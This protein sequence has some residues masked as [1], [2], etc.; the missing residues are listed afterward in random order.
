MFNPCILIPVYNHSQ[1]ISQTI[2]RI[3]ACSQLTII[4]VDDGSDLHHQQT[5]QQVAEQL[6]GDKVEL[7]HL[8]KNQGKG[9]AVIWGFVKA[10]E[11]GFS[12]ALQVDADGQHACEDIP[13][14]I[15]IAEQQPTAVVCGI[16]KYDASVPKGRLY[17]RY[18]TH[19]FVW[20]ETLSLT[21]K[22]SMCGFRLYPLATTLPLVKRCKLGKR[23]D[24][25]TEI[26]VRLYWQG[27]IIENFP[28]R[29]T[30][31]E[32]GASHFMMFKDNVLISWM[33]TRLTCGMLLRSPVLVMRNLKRWCR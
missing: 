13:A 4:L 25:D 10:A 20:L 33:H 7:Y 19:V 21:I 32:D 16:P 8:D 5:L 12:H 3:R 11:L 22:D 27:A 6:R 14:M 2:A 26:L 28:T 17:G 9:R 31:P 23:M 29:V 15:A 18:L 1:Y 30:Y 24:F